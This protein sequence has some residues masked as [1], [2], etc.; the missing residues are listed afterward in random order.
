M[1]EK[2]ELK[3]NIYFL[4]HEDPYMREAEE[5]EDFGGNFISFVIKNLNQKILK[6][7]CQSRGIYRGAAV[8]QGEKVTHLLYRYFFLT[9]MKVLP[10]FLYTFLINERARWINFD[11]CF[12]TN[13]NNF[14]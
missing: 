11:L 3:A 12:T 2:P 5:I 9:S 14:L 4:N 1:N 6:R 7:D 8:I 10:I 13:K